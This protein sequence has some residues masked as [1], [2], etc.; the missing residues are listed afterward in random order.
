M[1]NANNSHRRGVLGCVRSGSR[2]NLDKD[3]KEVARAVVNTYIDIGDS[4]SSELEQ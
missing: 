3:H 1:K 4:S 2:K